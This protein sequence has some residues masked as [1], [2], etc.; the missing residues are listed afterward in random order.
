MYLRLPPLDQ[1]ELDH[2]HFFPGLVAH[3]PMPCGR[4][5]KQAGGLDVSTIIPE[6]V[7]GYALSIGRILEAS[8]RYWRRQGRA[9]VPVERVGGS[10]T[11]D[12]CSL[13]G[14]F[15]FAQDSVSEAVHGRD[16]VFDGMLEVGDKY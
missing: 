10:K 3:K 12:G 14:F 2:Y 1:V 9:D 5:P 11:P 13:V 7:Y 4:T 6:A 8:D 16:L 15:S